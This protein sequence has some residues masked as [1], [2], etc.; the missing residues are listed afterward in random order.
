[1]VRELPGSSCRGESREASPHGYVL[2]YFYGVFSKIVGRVNCGEIKK[3][4]F[5][6]A[7]PV[8]VKRENWPYKNEFLRIT[9]LYKSGK[10]YKKAIKVKQFERNVKRKA[11]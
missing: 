4:R 8:K 2:W 9:N 10:N 3:P 7:S 5:E 1:M 11:C 6:C